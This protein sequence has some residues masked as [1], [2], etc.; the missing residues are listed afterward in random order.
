MTKRFISLLLALAM[1]LPLMPAGTVGAEVSDTIHAHGQD[2]RCGRQ[3]SGGT[4]QWTQ[5]GDPQNPKT[6]LPADSGHY[7][8]GADIQLTAANQVAAGKDITICLNGYNIRAKSGARIGYVYGK[9]TIADCGAYT[10]D[11]QYISGSVVGGTAADGA[12]LGIRRGGTLVLESGKLT[13]GKTIGTFAGGG[14]FIQKGTTAGPGGVMYMYGGEISGN[15]GNHG[16][17]VYLGGADA[18][19]ACAAFYMYGGTI[20]GNTARGNGGGVYGEERSTVAFSGGSVTGNTAAGTGGN[21]HISG[22][23]SQVSASGAVVLDGIHFASEDNGGLTINALAAGTKIVMTT[24]A[25]DITKIVRLDGRQDSW[26][27]HWIIANGESV[28]MV[29][30]TFRLGH[31]HGDVKYEPWVGG[32]AHNSLPNSG[33]NYYLANDIV[34]NPEGMSGGAAVTIDAGV[35]QRLC[36]N[37]HTITHNKAAERLYNIYGSF[38]LE[39][40]TAYTDAGGNYVSGGLTYGNADPS[41]CAYG[42][43][44]SVQRGGTLT[45]EDGQIYGFRSVAAE[46]GAAVY[47]QGAN[48]AAKAVFHLRGGEIHSNLTGAVHLAQ[49]SGDPATSGF[50]EVNISGGK[51]RDNTTTG[52]GAVCVSGENTLTIS[53]DPTIFDNQGG[54]LYLADAVTIRL[55]EMTGGKIGISAEKADRG[56]SDPQTA[57]P[58]PYFYSDDSE[59]IIR[60]K[61]SCLYLGSSHAHGLDG[62]PGDMGF[63]RW[64]STDSLPTEAGCYYLADDVKMKETFTL[65][66]SVTLC[67]NGKTVT[68][69]AGKRILA[70]A[71]GCT[72]TI[73]DCHSECGTITGGTGSYGGAFYLL[74]GSTLDLYNGC[75]TGNSSTENGGAVYVQP[76]EESTA[77]AVLNI[78]GGRICGNSAKRGGGVYTCQ[79]SVLKL[80]G[81]SI[82]DNRATVAAGGVY[83]HSQ[84]GKLLAEGIPVVKENKLGTQS[85]N[86]CLMGDSDLI[87]T[88]IRQGAQ[89]FI[90]AEKA[91]RIISGVVLYEEAGACFF[92]DSPFREVVKHN[93]YIYCNITSEHA[94][95]D[96]AGAKQGCT[97]LQKRWQAWESTDSLPTDSGYYYLLGDVEM[98][99]RVTVSEDVH[100]CLNGKTVTASEG[101]RHITVAANAVVTITDCGDTGRLT[102]GNSTFGAAVNVA[103]MGAFRMYGGSITGNHAKP[104][105]TT[106]LGGAVYL[107]AGNAAE[108]GAAFQ[109]YGGSIAENTGYHGGGICVAPGE[110]KPV[111]PARLLIAGGRIHNNAATNSGGGV[112]A[113]DHSVLTVTGGSFANNTA[114]RYGGGLYFGNTEASIE[115]AT[116]TGNLARAGG[117]VFADKQMKLQIDGCTVQNNSADTRGAGIFQSS[118]SLL[119]VKNSKIIANTGKG[120]GSAIYAGADFTLESTLITGNKTTDGT[121]VYVVP[122]RDDANAQIRLGG[123]LQIWGNKGTMK[124]DLYFSKGVIAYGTAAGFGKNTKIRIQIHSGFLTDVLLAA[125]NYEGGNRVY[126]VTYGNRSLT[127]PECAAVENEE[128]DEEKNE[129]ETRGEAGKAPVTDTAQ[130]DRDEV[131]KKPATD[132]V[133][134]AVLGVFILMVAA[135]MI[136][137]VL[138]QK[139]PKKTESP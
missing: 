43:C 119:T 30:G 22:S 4:V 10:Q 63:T 134:Y 94:H 87:D 19:C 81:G 80:A 79:G 114:Q 130:A 39:D 46:A 93:S 104:T 37:G 99:D 45:M 65:A 91:N 50:S 86:I 85:S 70:V 102:G 21:V 128:A 71:K 64:T 136:L 118:D 33:K 40:C 122:A 51:I 52:K 49:A 9:L 69:A 56:V 109:M 13:G 36:L 115:N 62:S 83:V 82:T 77:G 111:K 34:R 54:N 48:A 2:H 1:V 67:L 117:G 72:L 84:I 105:G 25:T 100:I 12:V 97:H 26:N 138:Y 125:Y 90:T 95:C 32:T 20:T 55:G 116:I 35:T 129:E 17:A 137:L 5:W 78:Y 131:E 53:G 18:G 107:Q 11:G 75:I 123:D 74:R 59:R 66:E 44:I 41:T 133:L 27:P 8:L 76:A 88:G 42:S 31:Y 15:E 89:L 14:V 6:T 7:Y 101:K 29:E 96:C 23:Q 126:T 73:T 121:A 92:S 110:E 24:P 112:Y 103:R 108:A 58:T 60:Y 3:C 28:S 38:T 68:A 120:A 113:G 16:G 106:G 57:D 47:V 124:G 61:E 132:T 139:K 127:D 98:T 135:G